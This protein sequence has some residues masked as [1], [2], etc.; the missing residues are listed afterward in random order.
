MKAKATDALL[1]LNRAGR[2]VG[3][4]AASFDLL[5]LSLPEL[6][7]MDAMS[8]FTK[9]DR[10][11]GEYAN[12]VS[13]LSELIEGERQEAGGIAQVF[14]KGGEAIVVRW[15]LSVL[16]AEGGATTIVLTL[17]NLSGDSKGDWNYS[18]YRDI[19]EHAIE[20]MYCSSIDGHYLQVNPALARMYGYASTEELVKELRDLNTQLYLRP[21]RRAEFLQLMNEHGWVADFESQVVRADGTLIWITE[22]GRAVRSS[23]GAPLY[24]EGSVIDVTERKRAEAAL[25]ASEEKFRHLIE[26]TGVVP[27]EADL[28]TGVFTY[29]GPQAVDFLGYEHEKWLEPGFW[30]SVAHDE[31]RVWVTIVRGEAIE[32]RQRFECEYRLRRADGQSIWTRE[33]LS[34]QPGPDGRWVLGGFMLDVSYRRESEA[35]LRESQDF[36]EQIAAA[37]PTISYLYDPLRRQC[38]YVNGRIPDILGY[39]KGMLSEMQPLF[40]VSLA[41]P[42]EV[43]EHLQ[44]FEAWAQVSTTEV[45]EREFRLRNAVGG[46]VWLHSRECIFK[47]DTAGGTLRVVGTLEDITLQRDTMDELEENE[48]IFRRLAETTGAVPFDFDLSTQRFT[49]VGPQAERMFGHSMRRWFSADFWEAFVHPDDFE[50]GR[51]F[52]QVSQSDN[53]FQAEFR[54]LSLDARSIWIRQIVHRA[55]D[56]DNRTHVRGFL[57]DVTE[58][59]QAEEEREVSRTQLR[60]LAARGQEMREEERMSIAREIH[61]ELG[62]ALTLLTIDL[63]WLGTRIGRTLQGELKELLG[64]KIVVMEESVQSTLQIVR[65]ILCALRPPLLDELGLREAIEWQMQNFSKRVGIRYEMDATPITLLSSASVTAVFRIFQ[66]VLTNAARH[67]KASRIKVLLRETDTEFFMR[68]EDN[69]VGI[70]PSRLLLTKNF[71]LLGMRERAWSVGGEVEITGIPER[72]TAVTLRV[73]LSEGP[74]KLNGS[75]AEIRKS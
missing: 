27:W 68:V 42:D 57:F 64:K 16:E 38:T 24:F 20:G 46:W 40:I 36:I 4:N 29:I 10:G 26:M 3:G 32:K 30:E 72:G 62:Q 23:E 70:S 44:Y 18:G 15:G 34:V 25:K 21:T 47:R 60:E 35:L 17:V 56:E 51:R 69:G 22:F 59:K 14:A 11:A 9:E 53:D 2:I 41:H 43:E 58:A 73:P 48:R 45:L 33:I 52:T 66:E 55:S 7:Q 8:I 5:G 71:G 6:L 54:V 61:D 37:S 31:D 67:S 65:R 19:F 39:S 13:D 12:I 63:A 75:G 74:L 1:T 49:Y 28:E 50:E